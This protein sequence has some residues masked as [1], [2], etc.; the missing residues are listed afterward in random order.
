MH[1]GTTALAVALTAC[2]SGPRFSE[3]P[4]PDQA[5]SAIV[6]LQGE[7]VLDLYATSTAEALKLPELSSSQTRTAYFLAF[8]QSLEELKIAAGHLSPAPAPSDPL[9]HPLLSFSATIA[10]GDIGGWS[11]VRNFEDLPTALQTFPLPRTQSS[12]S[13]TNFVP[14]EL[15]VPPAVHTRFLMRL[16][17]DRALMS[18]DRTVY[19]IDAQG[20]LQGTPLAQEL[21][22]AAFDETG[23]LWGIGPAGYGRLSVDPVRLSTVAPSVPVPR[24]IAPTS[25]PDGFGSF[26]LAGD[27]VLYVN[28]GGFWQSLQQ[29]FRG[30]PD[31][32]AG[33]LVRVAP[34]HVIAA[35]ADNPDLI[36][37]IR[38]EISSESLEALAFGV[39]LLTDLG[40]PLGVV[41]ATQSSG[42]IYRWDGSSFHKIAAAMITNVHGAVAYRSGLLLGSTDAGSMLELYTDHRCSPFVPSPLADVQAVV[43]L[44]D[45]PLVYGQT[46]GVRAVLLSPE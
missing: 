33:G 34:D 25:A 28:G 21:R 14:H 23:A 22:A 8:E 3:S 36:H 41:A 27:G 9:R 38:G 19:V 5:K 40:P 11:P 26:V 7:G 39:T 1:R 35:F 20:N 37:V 42:N 13:C 43:M 16:P 12:K 18:L 46:S 32:N 29:I 24:W 6:A 10:G 44:G 30:G 45:R 4:A 31:E 2:S 15:S 17:P